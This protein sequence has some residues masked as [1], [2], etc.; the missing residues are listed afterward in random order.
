MALH[1]VI[2]CRP[3]HRLIRAARLHTSAVEEPEDH[4]EN[5]TDHGENGA[6]GVDPIREASRDFIG[7]GVA[8]RLATPPVPRPKHSIVRRWLRNR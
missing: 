4:E 6:S 7:F 1:V 3:K 5:P 2:L 8:N